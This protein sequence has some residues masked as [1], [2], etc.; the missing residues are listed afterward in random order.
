MKP[1][2]IKLLTLSTLAF[3]CSVPAFA[4][5]HFV[6]MHGGAHAVPAALHVAAPRLQQFQQQQTYVR[7][8]PVR[9][10][11]QRRFEEPQHRF[12]DARRRFDD[13]R[14]SFDRPPGP[15]FAGRAPFQRRRQLS[16]YVADAYPVAFAATGYEEPLAWRYAEPELLP[17]PYQAIGYEPQL[18]QPLAYAPVYAPLQIIDVAEAVQRRRTS[19]RVAVIGGGYCP[20][21]ALNRGSARVIARY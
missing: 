11:P 16:V 10:A 12:D 19:G 17:S 7:A 9:F 14:R 2:S 4:G 20:P 8:A 5:G 18:P 13:A 15:V 1:S 3:A 21:Q 6:R